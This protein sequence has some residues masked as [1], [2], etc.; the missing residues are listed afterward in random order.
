MFF[1]LLNNVVSRIILKTQEYIAELDR[2]VLGDKM[3]VR[4]FLNTSHVRKTV[5]TT[6]VVQVSPDPPLRC[7][8]CSSQQFSRRSL[9][10]V[11]RHQLLHE[12]LSKGIHITKRD[13]FYTDVKLFKQQNEI[14]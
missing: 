14:G 10:A 6:R 2:N 4:Q 7:V 9:V 3:S 1:F 8:L 12:I 11:L 13:L 5:I